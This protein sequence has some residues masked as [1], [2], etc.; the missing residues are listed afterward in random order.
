VDA[1]RHEERL[2]GINER[3]GRFI[4]L[5][6]AGITVSRSRCTRDNVQTKK[7]FLSKALGCVAP[8]CCLIRMPLVSAAACFRCCLIPLLLDSAAA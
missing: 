8:R 5:P 4:G 2:K 1:F 6:I 3:R 7:G